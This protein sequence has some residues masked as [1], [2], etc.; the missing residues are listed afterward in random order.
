MI[1]KLPDLPYG[2]NALEPY[3]DAQTMEIHHAR[4]HA[5]YINN[6][7]KLLEGHEKLLNLPLEEIIRDIRMVPEE[8][9]QGVRNHGGGHLNHSLFWQIMGPG[10]GGEPQ[11][12][13]IRALN[14]AFGSYAG[15]KDEF[16]SAASNRFGSGW[17]WLCL[18][19]KGRLI[20]MSTPNQ[21]SPLMQGFS[22]I[23]G[24]D[25]WEHAYYLRYQ[26]RRAEYIEQWYNTLNWPRVGEFY[27]QRREAILNGRP[28][29]MP[30]E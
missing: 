7:N 13:L 26:N 30:K 16:S 6:L 3:I 25:V 21:D 17:A 8:I 23:L 19:E 28:S 20:T 5:G 4:H 27:S 22:P 12:E 24:I 9:R 29:R 11:G 15:F 14:A 2:Y 1:H 10:Q 18:D